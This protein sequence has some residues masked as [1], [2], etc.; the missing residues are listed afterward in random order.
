MAV[1][2]LVLRNL[3]EYWGKKDAERETGA[4]RQRKAV[5]GQVEALAA[6]TQT[7]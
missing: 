6:G 7:I 4:R 3:L 2:I 5:P 1:A